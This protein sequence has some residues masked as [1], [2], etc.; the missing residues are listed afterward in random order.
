MQI[1]VAT[2]N[3]VEGLYNIWRT[4][5]TKDLIFLNKF[6]KE[7]F[8][9]TRTYVY[10]EKGTIV[11]SITL[12]PTTYIAQNPSDNLKGVYLYG[13]CTLPDFRGKQLSSHLIDYAEDDCRDRGY[14][15]IITR[16]A[17]PSL[18]ALYRRLG[19][20]I[21]LYRHFVELPLPIF[22]E[23]VS[24]SE[25]HAKRLN[26]LRKKY[27]E[28]NYYAWDEN[29]LEYIISFYGSSKGSI[30][31]LESDRYLLGYPDDEDSELYNIVEIGTYNPSFRF[32]SFYLAGNLI[33]ARHLERTRAK[34]YF[35]SFKHYSDL[36][37][38]QKE[39]FTL[40]RPINKENDSQS[41]FNF[42]ME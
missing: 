1:F 40:L 42:S 8:P 15:F 5:F 30:V 25:I 6:F 36:E 13:V 9:L 3:D 17:T 14:S 18:F 2:Q 4:C 24:F 10:K 22:A 41:F 21:P 39:V 33:K 7:C 28:Y 23:N 32:P 20:S 34:I 11:S 12:M 16:P 38:I 19:F 35:P 29:L 37:N 27:L 26:E 31:E